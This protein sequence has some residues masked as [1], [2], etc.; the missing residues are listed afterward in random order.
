VTDKEVLKLIWSKEKALKEGLLKADEARLIQN[1]LLNFLDQNLTQSSVTW[2]RYRKL[3]TNGNLITWWSDVNGYP[4][5]NVWEEKFAPLL[6]ILEQH[7]SEKT[8]KKRLQIGDYWV[9]TR[10]RDEDE[11]ILVGTRRDGG[12]KAHLTID[13]KTG[14][15][16]IEDNQKAPEE[17]LANIETILTLKDGR[18]I[19]TTRELL[20]VISEAPA[21]AEEII[22]YAAHVVQVGGIGSHQVTKRAWLLTEHAYINSEIYAIV[23]F[24]NGGDIM[25]LSPREGYKVIKCSSPSGNT[26]VNEQGYPLGCRIILEDKLKNEILIECE[27]ITP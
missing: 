26:I 3:K 9:E 18:K 27:K 21:I 19:R 20:E 23:T 1:A 10:V 25:G 24:N 15:I 13:G 22:A 2:L 14:E 16:R 5:G 8:I 7:L 6:K 4:L 11:T 12:N 17:L